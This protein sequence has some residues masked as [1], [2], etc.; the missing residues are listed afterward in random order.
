[1]EGATESAIASRYGR[2][3]LTPIPERKERL[4]KCQD[5]RLIVFLS[6]KM[7]ETAALQYFSILTASFAETWDLLRFPV[8]WFGSY[9][10]G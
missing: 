4:S 7:R 1:M 3:K 10:P 2:V 8:M 6:L 9:H 5:L